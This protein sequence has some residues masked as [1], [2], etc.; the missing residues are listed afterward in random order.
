MT[1]LRK[2]PFDPKYVQSKSAHELVRDLLK[3]AENTV[4]GAKIANESSQRRL[5]QQDLNLDS[6]P[7]GS[8][9]RESF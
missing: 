8:R 7:T 3:L 5:S 1:D 2:P 4:E 6:W 9:I